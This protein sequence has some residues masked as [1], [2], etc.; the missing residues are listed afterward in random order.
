M[1]SPFASW[2][3]RYELENPGAITADEETEEDKLLQRVGNEHEQI[4][5]NQYKAAG[6]AVA[7]VQK[8]NFAKAHGSTIAALKQKTAI[9][10]QAALRDGAFAG[11]ADFLELDGSGRYQVWDTKLA[12]SPKPYY[13][14]QLCCY[15]EMLAAVTSEGMV[16]RI[17]V[18]L[19]NGER[20]EF[21]VE[22]FIHYYRHLKDSFLAMQAAFSGSL[23]DCPE[24][25]PRAGHGRWTSYAEKFFLDKDHLVQV[26]GITVGQ[27][28]KLRLAGI[29]TMTA[30][31][32][33]GDKSIPKLDNG[34]LEKLVSQARLQS[35]T[36]D[37]RKVNPDAKPRYELLPHIGPNGEAIGLATLPPAD[38][39]DVFFDMEGYPLPGGLE[40]LFGIWARNDT[41]GAMEFLDWWAHDR[42]QEKVAFERFIDWVFDRWKKNPGMHIYHY[43]AYECSAVRR[44]STFHDTRQNEVDDL[45]RNEVL[46]D[47]YQIVRRSL[48][49]GEDS[50]SIKSIETVYRFKRANDIVTA[51][52]SIVQYAN[53]MASGEPPDWSSSP[54]LKGIRDY[55]EDDC[56]S[57]AELTEWLR[58]V[59]K[60]QGIAFAAHK[61]DGDSEEPKPA[62]PEI[63][64][65][66]E[67]AEKL[68]A[69]GDAVSIVLGDLV[70]YHRR[71]AK[72]TWWRMF[73]RADATD[74]VLRDDPACIEGMVADG[75]CT[76]EKKSLLQRYRFDPS[77]ECKI[78]VDDTVMFTHDLAWSFRVAAIDLDNGELTIKIGKKK[79]DDKCGGKF[80]ERGSILR[81]EFVAPGTIPDALF[82]IASQQLAGTLHRPAKSLLERSA[83]AH[84]LQ[85]QGESPLEAAL[86]VIKDMFG[87]CLVIQG[88]PGTGK[89]YTASCMIDALLAA[90]KKIGITSNSHK[91]VVNLLAA[92][93]EA[94]RRNGR[95]LIGIKVGDEP[96][97]ELHAANPALVHVEDNSKA[98]TLLVTGSS[99]FFVIEPHLDL[100]KHCVAQLFKQ[101]NVGN[102]PPCASEENG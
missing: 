49:I 53:W 63:A 7:E 58:T 46:V 12:L 37:D 10:Y 72:P 29:A 100:L 65:R 4:V 3:D 11:Y 55:N 18:I 42:D 79:L 86:R 96:D 8:E 34:T 94:A 84:P 74:D 68:R 36:R 77:Q 101:M 75:P 60:E 83:P 64:K 52:G 9:I 97:D 89:T 76:T 92:C 73:D 70:D 67:L 33:A 43:A 23:E 66:Q 99:R 57:N 2:L 82:D 24:P 71:E 15:S 44:L 78:D 95:K 54:I 41:T 14:I 87:G 32:A 59:A 61:H 39:A 17:G 98:R 22:D 21:R 6:A 38:A 35:G 27:M 30:L 13:P 80:P 47:L 88:P 45:L 81:N 5:L 102:G 16:E 31:G 19:G 62:D 85:K 51:S 25:L 28:K 50:Y 90:C 69:Q 26:A 20:V 48:R 91:A 1:A 93:G 40:Y 56:R